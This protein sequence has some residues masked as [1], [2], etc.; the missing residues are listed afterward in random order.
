MPYIRQYRMEDIQFVIG[1]KD[2]LLDPYTIEMCFYE[3][4]HMSA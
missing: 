3:A 2:F 4:Y 1:M